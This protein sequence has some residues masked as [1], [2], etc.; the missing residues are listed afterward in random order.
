MMYKN[1]TWC[2]YDASELTP[3]ELAEK[4]TQHTWTTCTAFQRG[5]VLYLNDSTSEDGAFECAMVEVFVQHSDTEV[6]GIQFESVTFGW[7]TELK[8]ACLIRRYDDADEREKLAADFGSNV[9]AKLHA[10]GNYC[11]ACA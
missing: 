2:I 5:P 1:R 11:P 10:P 7:M 3:E 9:T 4:L 6:S 8:A